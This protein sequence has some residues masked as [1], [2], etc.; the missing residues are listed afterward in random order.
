MKY[1]VIILADWYKKKREYSVNWKSIS[2]IIGDT[3][4][5]WL[6]KYDADPTA[7]QVVIYHKPQ[8]NLA[9]L[10]VE[11]YSDRKFSEWLSL[12]E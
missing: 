8:I 11:F 9:Q 10:A 2:K 12:S 3:K 5:D 4:T 7:L 6:I 1:N